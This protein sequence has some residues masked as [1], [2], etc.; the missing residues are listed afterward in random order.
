MS[1]QPGQ[2]VVNEAEPALGLGQV[3]RRVPP[4][5][6]QVVFPAVGEVRLYNERTAPL[7]RVVLRVGQH[8]VARDG[9]RV[10]VERVEEQHGLLV[11]SG[12]G[13]RLPEQELA[14]D[15]LSA[16]ALERFAGGQL[17]HY[18]QY[19]LRKSGW[20]VRRQLLSS[21]TRGL[22][23]ARVRL[24][25]HQLYIAHTVSRRP[26]PRLL[27]ADEVGLGKTIEA[28]LIFAALRSLGRADRVLILAPPSLIYQWLTELVRRFNE[29]FTVL[30][31]DRYYDLCDMEDGLTPFERYNRVIAP[32]TLLEDALEDMSVVPWDLVIVDEA[33]HLLEGTYS[34]LAAL[35]RRTRGLLLLTAT[36]LRQGW[37]T[38]YHLLHLVDPERFGSMEAFEEEHRHLREVAALADRLEG[39][40]E[41]IRESLLR[42]FPED[43][44]LSELMGRY[45]RGE[46]DRSRVLR[47]LIDRHGTGRVLVRNRRERLQGFPGRRLHP[48]PLEP[49][50]DWACAGDPVK[51]SQG[52]PG[53]GPHDPRLQ[54]VYDFL[55]SH[56]GEKVVLI[57]SSAETVTSLWKRFRDDTGLNTAVFHEGLNLLE[58]D[59]QVAYFA[60]PDGATILLS[61]EIGGEGRNFQFAHTLVLWD[62][63]LSPDLLEQRI[64]R[65]D[66]IGQDREI[67]VYALW[68]RDTPSEALFRWHHEGLQSFEHPLNGSELLLEPL[69]EALREVL[70]AYRPGDERFPERRELLDRLLERTRSARDEH[71]RAV[72]E[73]VDH[74]VDLNS[75]NPEAG[76]RLADLVAAG[77]SPEGRAGVQ[78]FLSAALENYGVQE[79]ELAE[80]GLLR[81]QT[82]S[83]MTVESFPGMGQD[84]TLLATW[85]RALALAREDVE[86][87]TGDHPMVEGALGLVLDQDEGRAT[88]AVWRGA[89]EPGVLVQFLFL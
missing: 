62:L 54:W 69:G 26:A 24:L 25:P 12:Q 23:G 60:Q 87:L 6:V 17:D 49:P 65:L 88:A 13:R 61:S 68:L 56:P 50:S 46:V 52:P 59:R 39:G 71:R 22:S 19:D 18:R 74:L 67:Q 73:S 33:H 27:L 32:V 78:A 41:G 8:A 89:P 10:R 77:E 9:T 3:E 14:D 21:P 84:R 79:E 75:F 5:S 37:R 34:E 45:R 35:G 64:G 86:F 4:R 72:L 85:E 80:P 48:E 38:E 40:A 44:G 11:Y 51:L 42:L 57:A 83:L 63:P 2:R 53:I 43:V 36:P 16:G 47:A 1:W 31:E 28:G 81:I 70:G 82:G 7:R 76:Q 55:R 20:E 66:R 29:L 15:H 30:D 58:R